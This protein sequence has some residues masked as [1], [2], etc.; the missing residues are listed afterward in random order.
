MSLDELRNWWC[1]STEVPEE[2]WRKHLGDLTFGC[3]LRAGCFKR[4]LHRLRQGKPLFDV[5][6]HLPWCQSL[7]GC[8]VTH[9]P[10]FSPVAPLCLARMP[11]TGE[12]GETCSPTTRTPRSAPSSWPAPAHLVSTGFSCPSLGPHLLSYVAAQG[13]HLVKEWRTIL[14]HQ[15]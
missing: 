9:F 8:K 14:G 15:I 13:S 7:E 12:E 2:F 1:Q 11:D 6:T 4:N 3:L 10:A 5:P